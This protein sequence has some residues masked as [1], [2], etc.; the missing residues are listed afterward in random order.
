MAD[1]ER[2]DK[3]KKL[4]PVAHNIYGT[5]CQHK[6][7][8]I[9][10]IGIIQDMIFAQDKIELEFRHKKVA[11]YGSLNAFHAK[12]AKLLRSQ[13]KNKCMGNLFERGCLRG[14]VSSAAIFESNHEMQCPANRYNEMR[15]STVPCFE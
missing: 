6:Q 4:L 15:S 1:G 9:I 11:V 7:D 5:E 14:S 8:V 13:R 2:R 10:A 3:D 12:A